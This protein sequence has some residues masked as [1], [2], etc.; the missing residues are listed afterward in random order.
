MFYTIYDDLIRAYKVPVYEIEAI[1][2]AF[3]RRDHIGRISDGSWGY[4]RSFTKRA[5]QII[6][7]HGNML[8]INVNLMVFEAQNSKKQ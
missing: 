7:F 8:K 1:K 6:K 2:G 3:V 4:K 5:F